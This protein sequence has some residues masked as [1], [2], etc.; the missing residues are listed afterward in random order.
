LLQITVHIMGGATIS[1][2][3][4]GVNGAVDQF[5]QLFQGQG[6]DV[7]DGIIVVDGTALPTALGVNPLAT[8]S[9]LAERSVEAAAKRS[10]LKIDLDTQNGMRTDQTS[11]CGTDTLQALSTFLDA[12]LMHGP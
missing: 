2:D 11:F 4:T 6:K 5:S 9:A 10:N 12:L 1:S 8:I 7:H 3:N